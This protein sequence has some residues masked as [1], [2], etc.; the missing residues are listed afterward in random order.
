[1][2][3]GLCVLAVSTSGL[4]LLLLAYTPPASMPAGLQRGC[5][6][7]IAFTLAFVPFAAVGAF[8]AARR[9]RNATGWLFCAIGV[10]S[11]V[12]ALA[13]GARTYAVAAGW[14]LP[15]VVPWLALWGRGVVLQCLAAVLL[16]FPSGRL[17]S[18]RWRPVAWLA[19]ASLV[20]DLVA[21]AVAPRSLFSVAFLAPQDAPGAGALAAGPAAGGSGAA[22]LAGSIVA[23]AAGPL[24]AAVA[25]ATALAVVWRLR[26]A[27]GQERL[28]L[29]WLAYSVVLAT[30][31][32][33]AHCAAVAALGDA[34]LTPLLSP[35]LVAAVLIA[36]APFAVAVAI[37]RYRLYDIDWL[38]SRTL[39]YGPLTAVLA[40]L[41]AAAI[42]LFQKVFFAL[43][44]TQSD[45]AAVV[46][47]L[48]LA[49]AFTPLKNALQAAVDARFK[50]TASPAARLRAWAE[51]VRADFSVVDPSRLA[52]RFLDEAVVTVRAQ[53]GAVY[54]ANGGRMELVHTVG[55]SSPDAGRERGSAGVTA[56]LEH[57]GT[58][59][60]LLRLGPS[61]DGRAYGQRDRDALQQAADAVAGVLAAAH[62][63]AA[64]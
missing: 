11:G 43:T 27:E 23:A 47:M 25:I 51:Q 52:S 42:T 58:R 21:S 19:V 26:H 53:G 55:D 15:A 48:V 61:A 40:G 12:S 33:A 39:V 4:G 3:W 5:T 14:P 59:L 56:P 30:I 63:P 16:V 17:P 36:G 45:A 2:A 44:G 37:L 10:L 62:R 7:F 6:A 60:G 8:V 46:S 49:A 1:V 13:T 41:Y 20:A 32:F 9:P 57:G 24:E 22:A 34:A 38:I 50:D 31:A 28:Q 64:R 29:K 35:L 54:L 18:P